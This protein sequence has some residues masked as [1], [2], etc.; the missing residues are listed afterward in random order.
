MKYGL[1]LEGGAM[2]GLFTA[3][4]IDVL[5]EN[6]IVFDSIVGVSA[7]AAFGC[8]YKSGQPG[9]AIRYNTRFCK[10]KRYC[11]CR[12]LI[13]TG[14][15]FGADFCYHEIPKKL[16]LFDFEAFRKSAVEFY[17]V[18][19]DVVTGKPV[20]HRCDTA[21]DNELEWIRASASMPLASRI[22]EIDG[23]KL[24]DGGIADSIPLRFMEKNGCGKNIVVLTQPRD[25]VKK[26]SRTLGLV[27][28]AMRKYPE[29]IRT[30]E[31]R[32]R[33]YNSELKYIRRAEAEERAFVIA[34]DEKLPIKRIEHDPD[35]LREVYR[36]GRKAAA[37]N[38]AA[39]REFL[40]QSGT[41]E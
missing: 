22:V 24:L 14:D 4:V 25:Y 6:G 13:R 28:A 33:M 3:G 37:E 29:L 39:I 19:T 17:V 34:P 30:A 23:Y 16:D 40:G 41:D 9:R 15:M 27:K 38:L 11:S 7:G 20:Y 5:M 26:K 1:V 2:R 35:V 31:N 21:D 8:N 36:R 32:H 18:C 12:S 10:D